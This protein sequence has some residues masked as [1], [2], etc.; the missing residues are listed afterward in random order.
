MRW[1]LIEI[2]LLRRLRAEVHY[3]NSG[4]VQNRFSMLRRV[5]ASLGN[6]ASAK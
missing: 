3:T 1:I 4:E 6:N 5:K 2:T